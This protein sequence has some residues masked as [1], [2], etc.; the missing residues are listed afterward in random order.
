MYK[1]GGYYPILI[2]KRMSKMKVNKV[3]NE[4]T[5]PT[6][7]SETEDTDGWLQRITPCKNG[8][9]RAAASKGKG[10]KARNVVDRLLCCRNVWE[11]KFLQ[12]CIYAATKHFC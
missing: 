4:D 9:Q 5:G 2:T 8:N 3:R 11:L 1:M 12:R 7:A 6:T 10:R